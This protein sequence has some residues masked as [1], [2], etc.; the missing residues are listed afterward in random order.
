MNIFSF[1]LGVASSA[2]SIIVIV[3]LIISIFFPTFFRYR[4]EH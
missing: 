4:M 1:F 3:I 2:D